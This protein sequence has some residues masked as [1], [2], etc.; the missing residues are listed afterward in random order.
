LIPEQLL[1]AKALGITPDQIQRGLCVAD[2]VPSAQRCCGAVDLGIT[3]QADHRAPA[4]SATEPG[5]QAHHREARAT[6]ANGPGVNQPPTSPQRRRGAHPHRRP[7]V[8]GG[9]AWAPIAETR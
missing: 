2:Q 7:G 9:A 4:G 3:A 1:T 6:A 8:G 5:D